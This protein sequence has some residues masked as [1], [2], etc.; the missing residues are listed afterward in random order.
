MILS[1][2]AMRSYRRYPNINCYIS[3]TISTSPSIKYFTAAMLAS[4][5]WIWSLPEQSL[6]LMLVFFHF[7]IYVTTSELLLWN[8]QK[9]HKY[10][11]VP[12]D[13]GLLKSLRYHGLNCKPLFLTFMNLALLLRKWPVVPSDPVSNIH[14]S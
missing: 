3:N 2:N 9:I 13:I 11:I 10:H 1:R 8:P 12:F 7:G 14:I 6:S 4:V 5:T